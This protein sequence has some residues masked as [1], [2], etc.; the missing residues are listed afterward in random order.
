MGI[1]MAMFLLMMPLV[2][3]VLPFSAALDLSTQAFPA[4]G[5]F[6]EHLKALIEFYSIF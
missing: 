6:L 2:I 1:I 5:E 3:A 4:L